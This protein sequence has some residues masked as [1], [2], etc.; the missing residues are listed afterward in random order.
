M[1]NDRPKWVNLMNPDVLRPYLLICSVYITCTELLKESLI[2]R[3]VVL[4]SNGYDKSGFKTGPDYD[5]KVLSLDKKKNPLKASIKWH[6]DKGI[7]DNDDL[8][9]YE[10]ITDY[11][12]DLTHRMIRSYMDFSV[13]DIAVVFN[14]LISLIYKIEKWWTINFDYALADF[15]SDMEIDYD[16][17]YP[18]VMFTIKMLVDVA[19][20][21]REDSLSLYND[22]NEKLSHIGT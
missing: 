16:N 18:G 9:V 2:D 14:E 1:D 7:I 3:L 20:G 6:L 15:D 5:V 10:R 17:V 12:N 8:N 19:L 13:I 22:L 21:D 4:Y 11:R